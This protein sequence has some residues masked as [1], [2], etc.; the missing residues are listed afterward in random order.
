[1]KEIKNGKIKFKTFVGT[2]GKGI[3]PIGKGVKKKILT[4]TMPI[5]TLQYKDLN[6]VMNFAGNY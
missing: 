1:M 5:W 3:K 6:F 4:K 2:M